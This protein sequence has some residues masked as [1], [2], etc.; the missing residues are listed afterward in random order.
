[1][2]FDNHIEGSSIKRYSEVAEA[3]SN[4]RYHPIEEIGGH[5]TAGLICMQTTVWS[6]YSM[7]RIR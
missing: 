7:R 5:Y 6:S 2:T 4:L 3:M 1:M